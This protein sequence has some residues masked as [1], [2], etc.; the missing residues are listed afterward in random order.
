M[1]FVT[2]ADPSSGREIPG[3]QY[4][5]MGRGTVIDLQQAFASIGKGALAPADILAIV[6]NSDEMLPLCSE[7]L[8]AAK[9]QKLPT[10]ALREEASLKLLSPIPRPTSMR[11]G[12]AFR[13]HVEA[14]RRN[15][16]VP[17]IPEF[18]Q[19]PIFYFT[20][21][22]AVS[23]PGEVPV[24]KL[25]REKLDF[26][27]E[28]AIVVGR[29]GKNIPA[30]KADEHIFG[31][32]V[33]NDWSA[34]TLQM[35]EMKLNL[36]PAKGKDFATTLGPY[37]ITRDELAP[38]AIAGPN[39]EKHDLRMRA[40][41][42]G[43]QVSDGNLKDMTWT[44]AQILERASYGVQLHSGEVI[45]SGTVG[46]GCFLELNGTWKL[47]AE[48]RGEPAPQE[49]W[50]QPGQEVVMEIEALGRLVNRVVAVD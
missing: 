34:R 22:L 26:E 33:M 5:E 27:L 48:K 41:V 8:K 40:Y 23:G 49:Q 37:L 7:S 50:L 13:Q 46:T 47:E 29:P 38:R 24:Q 36:G 44:F 43:K 15:R 16:G 9:A 35:E 11:D 3:I 2:F 20:N 1:R 45:G 21:H 10:S 39:G 17:M 4:G 12:Y 25:A 30:S 42:N 6:R 32:M 18:D 31:Y 19:F 14:A 28:A